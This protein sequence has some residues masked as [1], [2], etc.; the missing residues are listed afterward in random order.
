MLGIPGRPRCAFEDSGG[1]GG[2]GGT[3]ETQRRMGV[4]IMVT[5]EL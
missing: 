2:S 5:K 4:L 1:L 3:P